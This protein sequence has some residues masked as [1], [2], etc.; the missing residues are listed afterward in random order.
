MHEMFRLA[1]SF[2]QEIGSWNTESVTDM[3]H[4][5]AEATDFNQK[6]E[7][8]N[9]SSVTDMSGMFYEAAAFNGDIR[10]WNVCSVRDRTKMFCKAGA[11]S[12]LNRLVIL[13]KMPLGAC[14]PA[15]RPVNQSTV[16]S[17]LAAFSSEICLEQLASNRS[18]QP[19]ESA[20]LT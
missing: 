18:V 6:I 3:N 9:T 19:L 4:M 12:F 10:C 7:S 16:E 2:N 13:W 1:D 14:G 15:R 20:V 5:F 8:W 11:F 17:C